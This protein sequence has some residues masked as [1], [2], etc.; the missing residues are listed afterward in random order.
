MLALDLAESASLIE[1]GRVRFEKD[2]IILR[3]PD[4]EDPDTRMTFREVLRRLGPPLTEW[5]LG[6]AHHGM[7]VQISTAA[8]HAITATNTYHAG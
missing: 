2:Q 3:L 4:P 5:P 8:P 1:A 7:N 6:K